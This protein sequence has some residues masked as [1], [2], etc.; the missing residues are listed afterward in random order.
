MGPSVKM[1]A[2]HL[3]SKRHDVS[4]ILD[5]L[6]DMASRTGSRRRLQAVQATKSNPLFLHHQGRA[7]TRSHR[8]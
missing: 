4:E 6:W 5:G 7:A 1:I 3:N 8:R 2:R